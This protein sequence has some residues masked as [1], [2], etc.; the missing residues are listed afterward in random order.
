MDDYRFRQ[1]RAGSVQIPNEDV[2]V[3]AVT[4]PQNYD[5]AV[6]Q[7]ANLY[8][9]LAKIQNAFEN[10]FIYRIVDQNLNSAAPY[11]GVRRND[12]N[13]WT[14]S[15]GLPLKY[16]NWAPMSFVDAIGDLW[17]DP[18]MPQ[19]LWPWGCCTTCSNVTTGVWSKWTDYTTCS[20]TCGLK[21]RKVQRRTCDSFYWGCPCTGP[22]SRLVPCPTNPCGLAPVCAAPYKKWKPAGGS[23]YYCGNVSLATDWHYAECGS[24]AYGIIDCFPCPPGGVWSA[25]SNV[26]ACTKTCGL[27]GSVKQIRNCTS[28]EY[29][30]PC[31]G[32]TNRTTTCP[33]TPCA[34]NKCCFDHP[35]VKNLVTNKTQCGLQLAPDQVLHPPGFT[36]PEC[37]EAT[38]PL[39]PTTTRP[40]C[41]SGCAQNLSSYRATGENG[42]LI[43][44]YTTDGAGCLT[45]TYSCRRNDFPNKNMFFGVM[46]QVRT[47]TRFFAYIKY[48]NP[49]ISDSAHYFLCSPSAEWDYVG[50]TGGN[51]IT[52]VQIVCYINATTSG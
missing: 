20:K 23:K 34:G 17:P 38:T 32:P 46:T 10:S 14:Y 8:G 16:E 2:C 41:G 29:E 49:V 43:F 21:G 44:T 45:A 9:E 39:P 36:D 18:C 4:R 22:Y 5:D 35:L 25:W 12:D 6:D 33:K 51:L 28:A 13:T 40:P 37:I 27:C 15:D 31:T 50:S 47:G 7:C 3:Y 24:S 26:G 42:T 1:V 19:G 52:A 30:C 11:I 48:G